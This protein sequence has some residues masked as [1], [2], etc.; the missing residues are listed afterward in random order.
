MDHVIIVE[1]RAR[2]DRV[3]DFARLLERHSRISLEEE[4]CLVFDVNR[5]PA[6]PQSFVLYEVYR[7]RDAFQ[8]H[9][10]ADHVQRFHA[11]KDPLVVGRRVEFLATGSAKGLD[12]IQQIE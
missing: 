1:F 6:D 4:G 3:D 7:D 12:L 11:Q 10:A 2:P 5:D 8:A 9:E